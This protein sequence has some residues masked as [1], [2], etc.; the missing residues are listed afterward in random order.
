MKNV[1]DFGAVGDGKTL[2]TNAIQKAIDSGGC[3]YFPCGTYLTGT[4]YLKSNGGI[5]LD[6]GARI[7]ASHN[8]EDYNDADYCVQNQIFKDEFMVGTHLI[9]AVEQENVFISGFG[10]IDGDSHFWVNES[11]KQDYCDFWG[12]PKAEANRPAQMIFFA[13]CK[14]VIVEN[15]TLR[16]APFWHLFFHGCCDVKVNGITV[17]GERRMWVNDGIDIDC[18]SNVTITNCIIDTGDDGITLRANGIPLRK[19]EAVCENVTISNCVITSYLDYGIRI[20]VG[21]GIIRNCLFSNLIIKN[22]L[23]GIGMT[24]RFSPNSFCTSIEKLRFSNISV[25]AKTAL[26]MKISNIQ[27]HPALK[28]P[29]YIKDISFNDFFAE[30][31][32]FCSILGFDGAECTDITFNNFTLNFTHQNVEDDRYFGTYSDLKIENSVLYLK[33]AKNVTFNNFIINKDDLEYNVLTEECENIIFNN[34]KK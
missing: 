13:E 32:F 5:F 17:N 18:C 15:V 7:L 33:K 6:V 23:M 27:T 22:S 11:C 25:E 4:I 14:N 19:K 12:H 21:N 2:D 28:N 31:Q 3:V 34:P 26:E 16:Y 24:C 1:K 30:T 20:G 8:R 9:T 10:T 29:G